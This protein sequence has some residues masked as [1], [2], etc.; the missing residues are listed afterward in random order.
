[1]FFNILS[2]YTVKIIHFGIL[3]YVVFIPFISIDKYILLQYCYVIPSI[4]L[5]WWL[6]DNRCC[7]TMLEY[8]IRKSIY[9]NVMF[10]DC[11]THKIIAPIYDFNKNYGK[12]N[13]FYYYSMAFLFSISLSKLLFF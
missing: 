4:V 13:K 7:L 9:K 1:M 5:H 2:L 6:N 3:S 8:S 11:F 10:N 12:S